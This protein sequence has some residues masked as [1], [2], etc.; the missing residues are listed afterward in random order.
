MRFQSKWLLKFPAVF[1]DV[2][3]PK[4][5]NVMQ[6]LL[7]FFGAL[8]KFLVSDHRISNFIFFSYWKK[9]IATPFL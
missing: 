4:F 3:S 7:L 5:G 1:V 6:V 8:S 9:I 2:L